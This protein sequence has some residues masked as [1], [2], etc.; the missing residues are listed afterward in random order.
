[1]QK[2]DHAPA[3]TRMVSIQEEIAQDNQKYWDEYGYRAKQRAEYTDEENKVWD[4]FFKVNP[5]A[6]EV[7][8][9]DERRMY[10][11]AEALPGGQST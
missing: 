10:V 2:E 6:T 7:D 1:M 4:D 5:N 3:S 8:F 11:F 9:Y